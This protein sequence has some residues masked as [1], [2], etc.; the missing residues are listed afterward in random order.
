M[1][2]FVHNVPRFSASN[3]PFCILH[4]SG[5]TGL[6]KPITVTYNSYNLH[7]ASY[8]YLSNH[9]G[10]VVDN[11]YARFRKLRVLLLAPLSAAAGLFQL[12]GLNIVHDFVVVLPSSWTS[13]TASSFD[14][15][16]TH[17]D[18]QAVVASPRYFRDIA[19]APEYL[20]NLRRLTY[21]GYVGAPCPPDVGGILASRVHLTALYGTTESGMYPLSLNA[22]EDWDYYS[23]LPEFP[24]E[25]RHVCHDLYE[26]VVRRRTDGNSAF[27]T[28]FHVFPDLQEYKVHDL[29]SRHPDPSKQAMW[30][31]RGRTDDLIRTSGGD[32]FLPRQMEGMIEAHRAVEG[33]I[34]CDQGTA[35]LA[36]VVELKA[37]KDEQVRKKMQEEICVIVE[38]A[39]EVSPVKAKLRSDLIVWTGNPDRMLR[40]SKGY[41]VRSKVVEQFDRDIKKEYSR[42][43]ESPLGGF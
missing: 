16:V 34:I 11:V 29:F 12:L 10:Q 3:H 18:V 5:T 1:P 9:S 38:E 25:F 19:D 42:H 22:P 37:L 32:L 7:Y 2:P 26:I 40:G 30:R 6:P 8:S 24:C 41:P 17:A 14:A 15:S 21:L 43:T 33:A 39:N 4:T 28:V 36:V 13:M 23:I 31:Y 20:E 35:G 27:Q